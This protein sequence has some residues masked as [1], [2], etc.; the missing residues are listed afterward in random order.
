MKISLLNTQGEIDSIIN[1][2]AMACYVCTHSEI[3]NFEKWSGND[4][5]N[6]IRRVVEKGH[7]SVLRHGVFTFMLRDVSRVLTHQLVR[8]T[9]G[10]AISQ[11]SQ[12]Y[13][14]L[15]DDRCYYVTP[16]SIKFSSFNQKYEDT[17]K[18]LQD[19]YLE[20]IDNDIEAEDARFIL[21][22]ATKSN[23]MF[24]GNG[25]TFFNFFKARICNR[26]QDEIMNLAINMHYIL[27]QQIPCIFENV[28][29]NCSVCKDRCGT[30]MRR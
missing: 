28:P 1:K 4:K 26:A 2:V 18:D 29:N 3:D 13:T 24:S 30:P 12:R 27:E 14:K 15:D 20:M 5:E 17:M 10:V 9:A 16:D 8:H 6:L 7:R 25:E 21:P 19:F 11:Q 22:N 23:I